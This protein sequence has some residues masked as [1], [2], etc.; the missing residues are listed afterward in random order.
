MFP[1]LKQQVCAGALLEV[2]DASAEKLEWPAIQLRQVERERKLA[3]EPRFHGVPVGR[4]Y[5]N[6]IGAGQ[7]RNMQVREFAQRLIA[8]PVLQPEGRG[9]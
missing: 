5:V 8:T 3:L 1:D 2:R 4:Y 7:H 6:G 9:D